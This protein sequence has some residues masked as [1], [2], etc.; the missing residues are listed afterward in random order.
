MS[1]RTLVA[2]ACLI[3]LLPCSAAAQ[4]SFGVKGGM[5]F[6]DIPKIGDV[7]D[8]LGTST[9]QRIGYAAGGFLNFGFGGFSIQPEVLY[10]QKGVKV[11]VAGGGAS[12]T[13]RIKTD[14]I[15]VPI[16]ARYTIGKGVRA[17][18]LAG[19]SFDFRTKAVI[20][21]LF[22]GEEDDEDVSD[23]VESFELAFV[24]GGGIEL[25]PFLAEARW[26]EGLTNLP[27]SEDGD[28]PEGVK[29]RTFLLLAGFR[30]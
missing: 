11:E 5:T 14:F 7:I 28:S 2:T 17:Y 29:T 30:F 19:P 8:E 4:D 13:T 12:A 22:G 25:G 23:D 27:K 6:G 16:L 3:A 1:I 10:T 21:T 9:G 26:S 15:D 24:F 20:S 18:F